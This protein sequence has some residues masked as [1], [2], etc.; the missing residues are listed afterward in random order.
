VKDAN[1]NYVHEAVW[2]YLFTQPVDEVGM[3]VPADD[4]CNK[5][6]RSKAKK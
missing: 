1:G 6:L 4:S 5:D 2:K 3:P